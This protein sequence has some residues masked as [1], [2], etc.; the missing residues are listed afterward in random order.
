[1]ML[2]CHV[3]SRRGAMLMIWCFYWM[4][5]KAGFISGSAFKECQNPK[6]NDDGGWRDANST[7]WPRFG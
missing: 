3:F 1:M 4:C 6:E 2:L 5:A 7:L